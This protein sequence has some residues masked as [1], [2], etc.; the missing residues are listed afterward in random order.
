[1]IKLYSPTTTAINLDG[2]Q[3]KAGKDGA[4]DIPAEHVALC[5]ESFGFTDQAPAPPAGNT[6]A[7]EPTLA[8]KL[9]KLKNKAEVAAFAKEQFGLDL[10]PE[11]MKREEMEEAILN[12]A[13]ADELLEQAAVAN[14]EG[15][16]E[17]AAELT[18]QANALLGVGPQE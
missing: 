9:D 15:R 16:H 12:K 11:E 14:T 3:F 13:K 18:A 6:P 10:D 4:F 7:P 17:D 5:V 1:M 8:E 2:K